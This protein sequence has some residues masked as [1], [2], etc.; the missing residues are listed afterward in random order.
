MKL[1][2]NVR[3]FFQSSSLSLCRATVDEN[4]LRRNSGSLFFSV[5]LYL[6]VPLSLS[7]DDIVYLLAVDSVYS[8]CLT[9]L[10]L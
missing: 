2:V 10:P 6:A 4:L 9:K 8:S 1:C 7:C 3:I 5:S